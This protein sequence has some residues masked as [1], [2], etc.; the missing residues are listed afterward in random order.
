MAKKMS[1]RLTVAMYNRDLT[2]YLNGMFSV[3]YSSLAWKFVSMGVPILLHW[4][5][6]NFDSNFSMYI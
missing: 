1:G 4:V 6:L 5:M 3:M 2:S